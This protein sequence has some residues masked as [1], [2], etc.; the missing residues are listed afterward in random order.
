MVIFV[1]CRIDYYDVYIMILVNLLLI[2]LLRCINEDF[3]LYIVY[4]CIFM[5]IVIF[6]FY[7]LRDMYVIYIEII[8]VKLNYF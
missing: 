8:L 1:F 2:V 6:F 4:I 3:D 7:I 5:V